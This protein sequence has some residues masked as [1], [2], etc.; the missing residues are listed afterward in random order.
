MTKMN[1]LRDAQVLVTGASEGIGFEITRLAAEGGARVLM[2]ARDEAKLRAAAA[3]I[4]GRHRP[5]IASVDLSDPAALEDFLA[6]LDRRAFVPDLVVN[7]AGHG[8]SGDFAETG[9]SKLDAMLRLNMIAMAHLT[10]WAAARMRGRGR[11]AIVNLSAAVATRPTPH[12]AAYAATK[13][14]VTNLSEAVGAELKGSGVTVSAVHPPTVKTTFADPDK[15][16]LRS[17][18]VVKLFPAVSAT[19]VARAVLRIARTGRRSAVVGPIA[20][21]VMASAPVMPR[22]LDLAFM[23]LLFKGDRAARPV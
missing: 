13:A 5:E 8:A 22:G 18:L 19:T 4:G 15:A 12:F 6:G 7:N 16:N 23:G 14:F 20:G 1:T 9:W 10:H 11:G 2:V 17:T 21:A 3:R